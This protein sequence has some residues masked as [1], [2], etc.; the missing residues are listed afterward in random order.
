MNHEERTTESR[1]ARVPG[2]N[3]FFRRVNGARCVLPDSRRPEH[4][5]D[6]ADTAPYVSKNPRKVIEIFEISRGSRERPLRAYRAEIARKKK[7]KTDDAS[8]HNKFEARIRRICFSDQA[9]Q[10]QAIAKSI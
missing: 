1:T 10:S 3:S 2:S 5:H 6:H 7:R 8:T 9:T 4:G